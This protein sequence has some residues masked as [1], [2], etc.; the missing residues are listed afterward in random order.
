M[1]TSLLTIDRL[2]S[3]TFKNDEDEMIDHYVVVARSLAEAE[4]K[5]IKWSGDY[6]Q[7]IPVRIFSIIEQEQELIQ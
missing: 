4:K 3:V 6:Y 1:T 5:S 7:E 2:Y